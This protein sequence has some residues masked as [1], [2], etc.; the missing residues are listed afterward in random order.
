MNLKTK[1]SVK[2]IRTGNMTLLSHLTE[3]RRCLIL[4]II[5]L[6]MGFIIALFLYDY[7]I[8]FVLSPLLV[9]SGSAKGDVL[10]INTFTEG[11]LVRLKISALAGF[12]LS[13][14]IHLFNLLYF[15]FPGLM[16]NEKRIITITLI[17]SFIFIL[18][19]IFYSYYSVIPASIAFLTGKGFIPENTGMLLSFGKNIFYIL[20]FML[21]ALVVF[22]LPIVLEML[23][24]LNVVKRRTLLKFGRYVIVLLFFIAAVLTPPDFLTQIGLALP[25]AGLYYLT[26]LIA[27]IFKFGEE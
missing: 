8:K 1:E 19:S 20:Q 24:V 26:I 27:K 23:L 11:F 14:P 9:L 3:L 12:I 22:Q 4:S 15:V 16:A 13:S 18:A 6:I 5:A 10:Y 2:P 21:I 25:M 17:A 7:I